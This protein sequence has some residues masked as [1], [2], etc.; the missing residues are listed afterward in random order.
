MHSGVTISSGHYTTYIRMSDLKDVK[1]WLQG[2]KEKEKE[3]EEGSEAAQQKDKVL[4][5]DD[6]EVSFSVSARGQASANASST[7]SIA[8]KTGGKKLSEGGVGLLGGQRSLSSYELSKQA[9]KT[10]DSR[11][12]A[13]CKRRKS[14]NSVTHNTKPELKKDA[15]ECVVGEEACVIGCGGVE[16]QALNSLL[17]YEGKWL[18][19]D[20]SEVRLFEEEDFLRACSPETCSSST[21][22]LLFY[23]RR[24]EAASV[25]ATR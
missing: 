19:F 25:N 16:H 15:G 17:Q 2:K 14:M 18:L 9:E 12:A 24:S 21:P 11:A 23:R 3:D 20:D 7:S 22:Y 13:R 5:Y 10:T 8:S 1:L 6:G 4:D